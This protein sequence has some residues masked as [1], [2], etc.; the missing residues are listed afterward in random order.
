MPTTPPNPGSNYT[1]GAVQTLCIAPNGCDYKIDPACPQSALC[2]LL[3]RLTLVLPARE[4][5]HIVKVLQHLCLS[6]C[7]ITYSARH[8]LFSMP[9]IFLDKQDCTDES[10]R[11]G[12]HVVLFC[13]F[14]FVQRSV[15]MFFSH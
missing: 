13:V 2:A 6:S 15:Y 10:S 11:I 4:Y 14:C 5:S 9:D 8:V 7:P 1:R 12:K 3:N